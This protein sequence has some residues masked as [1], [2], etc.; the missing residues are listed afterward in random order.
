M[1]GFQRMTARIL[2]VLSVF[3]GTAR[4]QPN[5]AATGYPWYD[6]DAKKNVTVNMYLFWSSSCPHCPPALEFVKELQKR[7]SWVKV[8]TFEISGDAENRALY[9]KMA[10]NLSKPI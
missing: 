10:G 8:K 6:V 3:A 5:E 7:H 4:A 1:I 9:W 2:I